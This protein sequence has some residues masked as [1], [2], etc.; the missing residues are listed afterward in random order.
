MNEGLIWHKDIHHRFS[1]EDKQRVFVLLLV[2]QQTNFTRKDLLF[3]HIIPLTI[4]MLLTPTLFVSNLPFRLCATDMQQAFGIRLEHAE[5]AVRP[6]GRSKGFGYV[7]ITNADVYEDIMSG[8]IAI[9]VDG[10]PIVFT[11]ALEE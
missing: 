3:A 11:V 8:N 5:I 1:R 10:K 4:G 2:R 9:S 7:Q 6:N